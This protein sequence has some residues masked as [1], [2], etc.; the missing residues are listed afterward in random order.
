MQ[1]IS[2]LIFLRDTVQQHGKKEKHSGS[3]NPSEGEGNLNHEVWLN[4]SSAELSNHSRN[5]LPRDNIL[6]F[7]NWEVPT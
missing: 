1:D 4:L 2:N 5:D 6:S 7:L 3:L